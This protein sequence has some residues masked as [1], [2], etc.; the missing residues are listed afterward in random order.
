MG[1]RVQ[2]MATSVSPPSLSLTDRVEIRRRGEGGGIDRASERDREGKIWDLSDLF[3]FCS[4]PGLGFGFGF[5]G[6]T[7][8]SRTRKEG[9][10][11]PPPRRGETGLDLNRGEGGRRA[12]EGGQRPTASGPPLGGVGS[13]GR[14]RT[15]G[16]HVL[17]TVACPAR[18]RAFEIIGRSGRRGLRPGPVRFGR[19]HS[20]V[21]RRWPGKRTWD[22]TE[23]VGVFLGRAHAS[24]G[25]NGASSF[26]FCLEK[27]Q[28][29]P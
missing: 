10:C 24:V 18:A 27:V 16:R 22:R 26:F 1:T 11:L 28:N 14:G 5:G 13:D 19:S 20:C 25:T 21:S 8:V 4:V 29:K 2:T 6:E 3:S 23:R 12:K 17:V 15:A 7:S 9:V